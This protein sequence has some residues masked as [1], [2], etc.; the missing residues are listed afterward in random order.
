M[1]P[2]WETSFC[3]SFRGKNEAAEDQHDTAV[4]GVTSKTPQRAQKL[5][6]EKHGA[7][8]SSANAP[9]FS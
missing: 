5:L 4:C 6:E 2:G 9:A 3:R 8:T 7:P 1:V